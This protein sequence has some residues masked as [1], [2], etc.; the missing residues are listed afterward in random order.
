MVVF[1]F[2][3]VLRGHG[4]GGYTRWCGGIFSNSLLGDEVHVAFFPKLVI[5]M[6]VLPSGFLITCPYTLYSLK[7]GWANYYIL[8]AGEACRKAST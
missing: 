1:L 2:I 8:S 4:G 3:F 7:T 5:W 6:G